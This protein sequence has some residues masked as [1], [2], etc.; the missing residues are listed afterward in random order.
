[1]TSQID[2]PWGLYERL[3]PAQ[4]E[5]IIATCPVA[6]VPWGALEF[7]GLHN[8]IGLDGLKAHGLCRAAA[9]RAGGV[10]LPPVYVATETIKVVRGF[11]HSV[12][13]PAGTVRSLCADY[14]EQLVDEGFRVVAVVSGHGSGSH[15]DALRAAGAACMSAHPQV[16]VTTLTDPEIGHYGADHAAIGETSLLMAVDPGLVDLGALPGDHVPTLDDDGVWGEDPAA[17]SAETGNAM[18]AAFVNGAATHV[19]R[20]REEV[21]V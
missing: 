11:K 17:S 14:L 20:L 7:H 9:Q 13:H 8:P 1:M 6:Y 15:V 10:V 4:I 12:E 16:R 5:A 19:R 3:R 18:L 21:N 2:A